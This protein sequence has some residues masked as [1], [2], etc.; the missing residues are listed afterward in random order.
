M[1]P[2]GLLR[3][4]PHA[5][6]RNFFDTYHDRCEPAR[7]DHQ[8]HERL[9]A[10]PFCRYAFRAHRG[11]AEMIR[12]CFLFLSLAA[13]PLLAQ[14]VDPPFPAH[15]VIGNIYYVGSTQLAS[16]LITTPQGHILIN[17]SY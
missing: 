3:R 8:P 1:E 11:G 6:T 7:R 2:V 13:T 16:F 5:E 15:R 17:S 12:R 10:G 14:A 4:W 9:R